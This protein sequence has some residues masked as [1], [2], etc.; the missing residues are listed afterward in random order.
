[1]FE[2]TTEPR[3]KLV[4]IALKAMLTPDQV[5]ELYRQEHHAIHAMG[6][7]LGEH[8]CIVD[9]TL[10][11]LQVQAVTQ[12]FQ[13]SIKSSGKARRLAMFTGNALARMQAR[14]IAQSRDNV[15]IFE[16]REEAE[17]W[18]FTEE[19]DAPAAQAEAG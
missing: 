16:L 8:I 18:L 12:A 15:A 14:R 1:M 13:S 2:I 9:L 7:K 3:R 5:A 4:R 17:A 11:P 6:C 19:P 10:C